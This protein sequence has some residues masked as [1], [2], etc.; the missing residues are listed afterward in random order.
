VPI[1]FL[2]E[3]VFVSRLE[4]QQKAQIALVAL[5]KTEWALRKQEEGR[6]HVRGNS[7]YPALSRSSK[8]WFVIFRR[9]NQKAT[10]TIAFRAVVYLLSWGVIMK[11]A[12][13]TLWTD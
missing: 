2:F 10:H 5:R 7:Q 1:W 11:I 8:L 3:D 9:E 12:T 13:G 6:V 4:M